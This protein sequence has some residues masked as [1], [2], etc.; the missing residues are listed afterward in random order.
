MTSVNVF[1]LFK[2]KVRLFCTFDLDLESLFSRSQGQYGNFQHKSNMIQ[3]CLFS[4]TEKSKKAWWP[5]R[6]SPMN[7][8]QKLNSFQM[9]GRK[10][11]SVLTG[12]LL[13]KLDHTFSCLGSNE[14]CSS[15]SCR[16]NLDISLSTM[17]FPTN[18]QPRSCVT[19][20]FP[21][22]GFRYP[23]LSLLADI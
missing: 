7:L 11:T 2:V 15:M 17:G 5:E 21:K 4:V 13:S 3:S 20:N 19:H 6:F 14:A 8:L 22:M 23:N 1:P 12:E 9:K 18:H 10:H 16:L